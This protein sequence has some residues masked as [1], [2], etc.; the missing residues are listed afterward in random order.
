MF[1]SALAYE[2]SALKPLVEPLL[3]PS[4][5][6]TEHVKSAVNS[7]NGFTNR[8]ELDPDNSISE[9]VGFNT[10]GFSI[11]Q[12]NSMISRLKKR[13]DVAFFLKIKLC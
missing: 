3:R 11:W 10:F 12:H 6:V 13:N 7:C 4:L 5:R 9:F 8:S 1:N 2:L